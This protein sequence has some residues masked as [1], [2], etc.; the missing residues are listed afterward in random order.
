MS[1]DLKFDLDDATVLQRV[2]EGKEK[3]RGRRE[4]KKRNKFSL[5]M[6]PVKQE[7]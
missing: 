5:R 2:G 6:L 1:L 4:R 3:V 7:K